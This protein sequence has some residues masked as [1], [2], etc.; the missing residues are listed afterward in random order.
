MKEKHAKWTVH[1]HVHVKQT[2][3]SMGTVSRSAHTCVYSTFFLLLHMQSFSKKINKFNSYLELIMLSKCL[4]KKSMFCH[5]KS[6]WF[7]YSFYISLSNNDWFDQKRDDSSTH[8][9]SMSLCCSESWRKNGGGGIKICKNYFLLSNVRAH[10]Q[11][12]V[13]TSTLRPLLILFKQ[14]KKG[15]W[16]EGKVWIQR[17]KME[18]NKVKLNKSAEGKGKWQCRTGNKRKL[19]IKSFWFLP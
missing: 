13:W 4:S 14:E 10:R 6:P 19:N 12:G 2:Q 8:K 7:L 3:C 15:G 18:T 9:Y 17:T 5:L 1:I 11:A 16:R